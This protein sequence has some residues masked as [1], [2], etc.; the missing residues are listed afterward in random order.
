[1][2]LKSKL[3]KGFI[4]LTGYWIF[5]HKNL[6][7]GCSLSSDL[8]LKLNLQIR[9]IFDVG[10]NIGQSTKHFLFD[11]PEATIY[12][13]EPFESAFGK[14]EDTYS[15]N[16]VKCFKIALGDKNEIQEIVTFEDHLSVLNSLSKNA[17]N[18]NGTHK[19]KI[20]VVTG[21]SF[22]NQHNIADIDLLKIDT[23]GYEIEVLN[24]FSKRL[25]QG[26]IKAILCEVGFSR[27]NQ[28]NTYINDLMTHMDSLDYHLYGMYD[29]ENQ[30]I[31]DSHNFGNL[32]FIHQSIAMTTDGI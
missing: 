22:A 15:A 8:T 13:F 3:R 12:A 30:Q 32:L 14:L 18:T 17:A 10:A 19:E 4:K 16:R 5:R 31:K 23:E 24:G 11:Y 25:N 9:T 7:I 6:P 26:N 21:D 28:R 27:L 2:T 1:M 29:V 20:E